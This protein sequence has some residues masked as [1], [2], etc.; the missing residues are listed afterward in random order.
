MQCTK[1][2]ADGKL[3]RLKRISFVEQRIFSLFGYYPWRCSAC[4]Q[5]IYLRARSTVEGF[6]HESESNPW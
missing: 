5:R 1:C 2:K 3:S 6:T 4:T